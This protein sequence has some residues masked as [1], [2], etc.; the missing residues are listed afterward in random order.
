M[1]SSPSSSRANI[2]P[3]SLITAIM[4]TPRR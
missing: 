3:S 1:S 2:S 4:H